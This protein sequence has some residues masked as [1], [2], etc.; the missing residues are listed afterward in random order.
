MSDLDDR[1][2]DLRRSLGLPTGAK[3][4]SEPVKPAPKERALIPGGG[5][6]DARLVLPDGTI[7]EITGALLESI[8]IDRDYVDATTFGGSPTYLMGHQRFTIRGI[9]K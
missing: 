5:T 8:T 4:I 9:F 7:L 2:R 6:M 1:W 3:A